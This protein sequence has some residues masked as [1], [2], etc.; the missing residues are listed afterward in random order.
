M[1]DCEALAK[2]SADIKKANLTLVLSVPEARQGCVP[3]GA[4]TVETSPTPA[5]ALGVDEGGSDRWRA[6]PLGSP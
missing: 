6:M 5:A 3:D 1:Q 2:L 4:Y